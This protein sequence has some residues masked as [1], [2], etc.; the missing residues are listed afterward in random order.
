M[1]VYMIEVGAACHIKR[2]SETKTERTY[3]RCAGMLQG[4]R[5]QTRVD[6]M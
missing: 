5:G 1:Y 3:I 4:P 6:S 2:L